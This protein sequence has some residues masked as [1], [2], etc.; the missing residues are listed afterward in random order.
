MQ[1][2]WAMVP[3]VIGLVR[4][5]SWFSKDVSAFA[6]LREIALIT[7]RVVGCDWSVVVEAG[8][9]W[10][11]S[12]RRGRL[13][14]TW[15]YQWQGVPGPGVFYRMT[16]SLGPKPTAPALPQVLAWMCSMVHG[17]TRWK[18]KGAFDIGAKPKLVVDLPI[19]AQLRLHMPLIAYTA[20]VMAMTLVR[21][22]YR[23]RLQRW[24]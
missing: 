24:T 4:K 10:S 21:L 8:V 23:V 1:Q 7:V 3:L 19:R 16:A 9:W 13:A 15:R 11:L 17:M 5:C 12:I 22:I 20:V 6:F 18:G 2:V 14:A